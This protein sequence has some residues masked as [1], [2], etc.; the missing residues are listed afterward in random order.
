MPDPYQVLADKFHKQMAD[1][2]TLTT[3]ED[4]SRAGEL[5]DIS[6]AAI[7]EKASAGLTLSRE[8]AA[9]LEGE[10]GFTFD[11]GL[12]LQLAE[13]LLRAAALEQ[14]APV[15]GMPRYA[16]KPDAMGTL[17]EQMPVV[18]DRDPREKGRVVKDI[19]SRLGLLDR[20]L[21][22]GADRLD[23]PVG[24]W[25]EMEI[26]AAEGFGTDALKAIRIFAETAGYQNMAQVDAALEKA[27]ASIGEYVARLKGMP[28]RTRLQIGPEATEEL[29]RYKG[30]L[31][32][33]TEIHGLAMEWLAGLT[34]RLE[35]MKAELI[36]KYDLTGNL[37]VVDV[38]EFL[39][40]R[41]QRGCS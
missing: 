34:E 15:D 12:D 26:E 18:L 41:F 21:Q 16:V 5:P 14:L 3:N 6:A 29:F 10:N 9:S 7:E 40:T 2:L 11:E 24:V 37:S 4:F 35:G 17:S 30:I 39:K 19:I 32:P 27:R 1:P 38:G 8:M 20:Y 13:N 33:P 23:R 31:I 36:R 28:K 22:Q 25:T